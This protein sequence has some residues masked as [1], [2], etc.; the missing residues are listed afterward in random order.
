MGGS[1]ALNGTSVQDRGLQFIQ[2]GEIHFIGQTKLDNGTTAGIR[3]ELKAWN[4]TIS[5]TGSGGSTIGNYPNVR[6]GSARRIISSKWMADRLAPRGHAQSQSCQK[7]EALL[8]LV[9]SKLLT[10]RNIQ[11]VLGISSRERLR[12]TKDGRLLIKQHL[13]SGHGSRFS[14]PLY[15]SSSIDELLADP[16]RASGLH[17]GMDDDE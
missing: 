6:C 2:E 15:S 1:Y 9:R 3:V 17:R 4:P 10:P 16:S 14:L 13:L 12:W 5:T 8:D 7:F 11:S